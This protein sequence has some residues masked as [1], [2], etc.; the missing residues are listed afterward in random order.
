MQITPS[1]HSES[2]YPPPVV[3]AYEFINL[4]AIIRQC[5]LTVCEAYFSGGHEAALAAL[6][7]ASIRLCRY[8]ENGSLIG[9]IA[10]DT[11][12]EVADNLTLTKVLG[13]SVVAA[14]IETGPQFYDSLA[15]AA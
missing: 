6:A 11:L 3:D 14:A 7:A 13:E 8:V 15:G 1:S 4:G 10:H 12:W 5:R 2:T 9:S